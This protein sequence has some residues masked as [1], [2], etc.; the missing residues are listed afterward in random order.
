MLSCPTIEQL[1]QLAGGLLADDE[2]AT[3]RSHVE[4]C[5]TCGAQFEECQ[6]NQAFALQVRDALGAGGATLEAALAGDA[7]R[8]ETSSLVSPAPRVEGYH[9]IRE[10]HR[11][12][13]GVVYEAFQEAT[14][15]RVALKVL[16]GGPFAGRASKRRFEREVELAASLRHTNI[17]TIHD[18]G[19][20]S[21]NY[22]F[23]MDYLEGQRL[24]D[25][26]SRN[27]LSVEQKLRLFVRVCDAVAHAHQRGVIHRDLKPSN[28]LVDSD[29][30][31]HVLDFGLA[32]QIEDDDSQA[33]RTIVSMD[34]HVLGTLAYMSP[35]QTRGNADG[36]DVRTDVYSLGVIL[37]ELLTG[38]FPYPVDGQLTEVFQNITDTLP[39]PPSAWARRQGRGD[40]TSGG[41]SRIDHDLE[42]IVLTT[43][44]KEPERRYQSTAH[45]RQD[46][47]H[48]LAGEP[49]DAKR[50]SSWYVLRKT[51]RR[52]RISV[53]VAASFVV[54][55]LAALVVSTMFWQR[56]SEQRD[57]AR[58]AQSL[59]EQE[60]AS[61]LRQLYANQ[62]ASIDG[63]CRSHRIALARHLLNECPPSLRGW[64]WRWLHR[65]S[66][67]SL[68]TLRGH[69]TQIASVAFAPDSR[70]LVTGG[71]DD[72]VRIF[73]ALT[74]EELYAKVH[75]SSTRAAEF[76]PDGQR[77][78]SAERGG[79]LRM[80]DAHTGAV[81]WESQT[82]GSDLTDASFS[83]DGRWICSGDTA[84][85]LSL[86]DAEKGEQ[87]LSWRAH[88]EAVRSV[89]V[90]PDGR[91]I[92]TGG[93]DA[94]AK[95]WDVA[96]GELQHTFCGHD[97][98]V[99]SAV[100]SPVGPLI[101]TCAEDGT[102]RLWS[103]ETGAAL[104]RRG[105]DTLRA[106]G[107]AFSPDG[108]RFAAVGGTGRQEAGP[109]WVKV[110]DAGSGCELV[111]LQGHD[112]LVTDLAF[113]PDGC[114]LATS[115]YD[116]TV[117]V[118][119]ASA[120]PEPRRLS[121]HT[122]RVR[123]VAF[124]PDGRWFASAGMDQLARLWEV[125]T[126]REVATLA[127]H[128]AK[129]YTVAFTPDSRRLVTGAIDGSVWVWSVATG[130]AIRTLSDGG[131][132]TW[133]VACSPDAKLI[134]AGRRDGTV[135]LWDRESGEA[136]RLLR[137]HDRVV[138][139]VLFSHDSKR[140]I[141]G[142]GD[143]LLIV[144]DVQTGERLLV[145]DDDDAWIWCTAQSP[146]GKVLATAHLDHT[147]KLWD[148]ETGKRLRVLRGHAVHAF[149]L[150][151]S[152]DGRRIAS[153]SDKTVK[154]WDSES[155]REL[156]T[157]PDW[158][159][160]ASAVAFSP[161]GQRLLTGCRD[162]TVGLWSALDEAQI[163]AE[164]IAAQE[165]FA[166]KRTADTLLAR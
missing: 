100:F 99:T 14:R 165:A 23:A 86:L 20:A 9:L 92:V 57:L 68:V 18:S 122:Q 118:W 141:S 26:T 62:I 34:G 124:S 143:G 77:I 25:Y 103:T 112:R 133:S 69:H 151:F 156:L 71:L 12:G 63:A 131:S 35:E 140:I 96:T 46:L 47:Q 74:G 148:A 145:V 4:S 123:G 51:L 79:I 72:A 150:V 87:I 13:Q 119:D 7:A 139:T 113:S 154:I 162:G 127:V 24:H 114:L 48:Y 91:Q 65:W 136:I 41:F 121:T 116:R 149:G 53:G 93:E 6:A 115:S 104:L 75:T 147:I 50:G 109:R 117:K 59:A 129:V 84:G 144:W 8:I 70:R 32:K 111:S 161:D 78:L 98:K 106:T 105:D 61:A 43:L 163:R 137:G 89:D 135:E 157:L 158:G 152:P 97:D 94:V 130:Q 16:L 159:A 1:E 153:G 60:A 29:G 160:G 5:T 88:D 28:I 42:S 166:A 56:T 40:S 134:A 3:I 45:L 155:G 27:D 142:G 22:Y 44:A 67:R 80:A 82:D 132:E 17:V 107:V 66:D 90:S 108:T 110:W 81:L 126:C 11:G 95:S 2:A 102:V 125:A 37:Y 64:E 49:I 33:A 164:R 38:E 55:V 76:S 73:D 31:P 54:V 146:D 30:E 19:I 39:A 15:R 138:T 101:A 128:G 52:H 10:I 120:E 85:T 58:E 83:P 36:I 21:G